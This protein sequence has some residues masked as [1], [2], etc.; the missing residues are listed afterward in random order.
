MKE[1]KNTTII[2]GYKSETLLDLCR[3]IESIAQPQFDFANNSFKNLLPDETIRNVEKIIISGCGDSYLAAAEAQVAFKKYLA[4]TNAVMI[5]PTIIEATRYVELSDYEPN[6]LIV[7]VSASGNPSRVVELI[8]RG[9]KHGCV[10]VALTNNQNSRA[11]NAAD[12]VYLTNTPSD[13]PGLGS[14]Y[15]SL[16]SLIVMAAIIGEVKLNRSELVDELRKE[17]LDYNQVFFDDF[18]KIVEVT[19]KT[20]EA[21]VNSEG[22]EVIADG[23]SFPCAQFVAAKYAEAAGILCSVVDSENYW[24]VNDK[25]RPLGVLGTI[26]MAFSDE[27]NISRIVSTTNRAVS[28]EK[29]PVLFVSDKPSDALGVTEKVTDC[30]IKVPNLEYRFL[31]LLYAFIP[32][33]LMAGFHASL[34]NEPYFR[35]FQ[36]IFKDPVAFTIATSEINVI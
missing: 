13:S 30:I 18:D 20:S 34:T 6:T 16:L 14:Y 5:A 22:F 1:I 21:L 31:S 36:T 29:R 25:L 27:P 28:Q 7:A 2:E 17:L 33:A 12:Y 32:G 26:I 4:G 35:G 23:P 10:T 9:K 3:N 19:H 15:A 11:G 8:E 24:H